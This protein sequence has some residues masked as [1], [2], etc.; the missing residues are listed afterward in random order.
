MP[1]LLAASDSVMALVPKAHLYS[2]LQQ[3][4]LHGREVTVRAMVSDG[5]NKVFYSNWAQV[6]LP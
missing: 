3:F 6:Q 1:P 5:T 2:T 4:N